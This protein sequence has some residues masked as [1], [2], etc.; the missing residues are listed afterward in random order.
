MGLVRE[1]KEL[2]FGPDEEGKMQ[3]YCDPPC[4][5][6]D[7]PHYRYALG[8]IRDDD[9]L[10]W[11]YINWQ[12]KRGKDFTAKVVKFNKLIKSIQK[13]GL[14]HRIEIRGDEIVDGHHRAAI[15]LA[16]GVERIRCRT[17]Q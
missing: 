12:K 17:V 13:K 7:T 10:K 9:G 11:D 5:V 6:A 2:R 15:M 8:C 16:L 4:K 3:N 14:S 1:I